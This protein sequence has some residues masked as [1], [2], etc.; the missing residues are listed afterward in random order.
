M[1]SVPLFQADEEGFIMMNLQPFRDD[2][3]AMYSHIVREFHL[4]TGFKLPPTSVEIENVSRSQFGEGE[5]KRF[6]NPR[7]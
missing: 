5:L 1:H 4:T 3:E 6:N 2:F 7:R